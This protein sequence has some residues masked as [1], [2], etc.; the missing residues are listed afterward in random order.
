MKSYIG[1]ILLLL[2]VLLLAASYF[3]GF[4]HFNSVLLVGLLLVILG[5]V[6]HV[7]LLKHAEKY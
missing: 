4:S 2:G 3:T 1:L 7:W 6:V 5:I